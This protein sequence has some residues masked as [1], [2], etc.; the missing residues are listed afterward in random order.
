[1]E[2]VSKNSSAQCV[3]TKPLQ[4]QKLKMHV[5]K[6]HEKIKDFQCKL[7]YKFFAEK[8]N[9]KNHMEVIHEREIN[10]SLKASETVREAEADNPALEK[11]RVA[12]WEN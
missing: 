5:K 2:V 3:N 11:K 7:C 12:R 6:V 9:V 10:M 8:Q 4:R 1:M